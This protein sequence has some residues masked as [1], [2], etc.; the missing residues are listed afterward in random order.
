VALTQFFNGSLVA[1]SQVLTA[2]PSAKEVVVAVLAMLFD[3]ADCSIASSGTVS[4]DRECQ[5]YAEAASS[6][7]YLE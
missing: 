6:A 1:S 2:T 7:K 3:T 5:M 4:A